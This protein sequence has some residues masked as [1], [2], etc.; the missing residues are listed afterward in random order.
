M[1]H[2]C[3]NCSESNLLLQD[4]LFH[5]IRDFDGDD[6]DATELFQWTTTDRSN[7]T[8]HT[9]TVNEYVKIVIEQLHIFTVHSYISKCQ[10]RHLKKLKSEIDSSTVLFLGDFEQKYQFVIQVQV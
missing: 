2:R 10:S 1:V 8:H 9:E 6:H 5:T 3:L 7:L 4:F